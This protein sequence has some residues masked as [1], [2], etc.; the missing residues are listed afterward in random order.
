MDR[1]ARTSCVK[2]ECELTSIYELTLKEL[3][4]ILEETS[5]QKELLY[6]E[7]RRLKAASSQ[8][9]LD[10]IS[11]KVRDE[12]NIAG[13][14]ILQSP[15]QSLSFTQLLM[16]GQT[17]DRTTYEELYFDRR[18]RLSVFTMLHL[19]EG[20][21]CW[22]SE[23]ENVIWT[24]CEEFT[25]VLPAHIG[26]Y[27]NKY[28]DVWDTLV[29]PRE[30][31]DLFAGQTAFALTEIIF[32]LGEDLH[33]WIG[34]QV[35]KEVQ[36]RIIQVY[37]YDPIPQIWEMKTNNWPAICAGCAGGAAIYLEKDS[38]RLAGMIWRVLQAMK[39]HLN[40][41]DADGATAEGISYWQFGFGY[42]VYFAELL[43]ER[44]D[45]RIDLLAGEHVSKIISFPEACLLSENRV[46]N[47][48]DAGDKI[49]LSLGLFTRLK[50]IF[51]DMS[52]P[53]GEVTIEGT[54]NCWNAFSRTVLWSLPIE[55]QV[56]KEATVQGDKDYYFLG[57]QWVISKREAEGKFAAFAAK[58]G[59]NEEPHNHNDLGHFIIHY[60]GL[61]V[62]MDLG[63]GLYTKQYF[64]PKFRYDQWTAGSQGHSV[65][66]VEGKMQGYGKE[67]F[68]EVINYKKE[69]EQVRFKLDLTRAYDCDNLLGLSREFIWSSVKLG[70]F[71]YELQIQD[72]AQFKSTPKSLDEVF[73]SAVEPKVVQPGVLLLG[74]VR[75]EFAPDG[76]DLTI[77]YIKDYALQN[78]TINFW[79]IILHA[80]KLTTEISHVFRF[81]ISA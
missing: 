9:R 78:S 76:W 19:I 57:H 33:P 42:Y 51:A 58:G 32:L 44:T 1:T 24:I 64:Q 11:K 61:N 53:R 48:S 31:V 7:A 18:R 23:L 69:Q 35:R 45:G 39:N 62:L 66:V 73:I 49:E 28:P 71:S 65:P 70:T 34:D 50:Q 47:F 8:D 16:F 68:A 54:L 30:S 59:F 37:F 20:G 38:A 29:P 25:W 2:G 14:K 17:G 41:F 60:N 63:A 77:E 6:P 4:Q 21:D 13:E 56:E 36:R 46:V 15:M 40:G 80:T 75:M 52:F 10:L 22:I 79:R 74:T 27:D 43:K 5:G 72:N 26:L 55:N 67:Y 81:V 3:K 12:L